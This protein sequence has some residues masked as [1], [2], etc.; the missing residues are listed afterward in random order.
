MDNPFEIPYCILEDAPENRHT[1]LLRP[2]IE[3]L[4]QVDVEHPVHSN[5]YNRFSVLR[6]DVQ[7]DT[8]EYW[9]SDN[10]EDKEI[11]ADLHSNSD[12][13]SDS[14]SAKETDKS[15]IKSKR[16]IRRKKTKS[17]AKAKNRKAHVRLGHDAQIRNADSK[18]DY[19]FNSREVQ[20]IR[21]QMYLS[22]QQKT[23]SSMPPEIQTKD[24]KMAL[25]A[26]SGY[27]HP[28]PP[29]HFKPTHPNQEK[30][31]FMKYLSRVI[32]TLFYISLYKGNWKQ[33]YRL[34]SILVR[35]FDTDVHQIW[36]LGVHMLCQLNTAEFEKFFHVEWMKFNPKS[37]VPKLSSKLLHDMA[38]LQN[39][40]L[41]P[42][43]YKNRDDPVLIRVLQSTVAQRRPMYDIILK[44]L[45]LLMRTS[46]NQH[47][48][49]GG[50]PEQTYVPGGILI[51]E[52]KSQYGNT[53]EE[54]QS[55]PN[56]HGNEQESTSEHEGPSR[57]EH[58]ESTNTTAVRRKKG[59]GNRR[60]S[61]T[62]SDPIDNTDTDTDTNT[63]TEN[64]LDDSTIRISGSKEPIVIRNADFNPKTDGHIPHQQLF[65]KALK[66]H[67]TPLHKQGTRVR[68]PTF[69][70]S[71]LWILV[72]TGRLSIVQ[73]ALE[74]L[75]LVVPT[76]IDARVELANL[77]SRILDIAGE[78][79]E[80]S[81]S[82]EYAW[83]KISLVESK[84]SELDD[85]WEKWK[86]QFTCR[87]KKRRKG[88]RQF[89]GYS[90]V[91]ASLNNLKKWVI[92]C[93]K[94]N[95]GDQKNFR[96][97]SNKPDFERPEESDES[98]DHD[99]YVTADEE[100]K[101]SKTSEDGAN[102]NAETRANA[103]EG[104]E[105]EEEEE[106]RKEMERLLGYS[107]MVDNDDDENKDRFGEE[108]EESEFGFEGE[109][110]DEEVQRE[111]A[112]LMGYVEEP[113][114]REFNEDE[115][116]DSNFKTENEQFFNEYNKWNN[117]DSESD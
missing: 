21:Q 88:V 81:V 66:R 58:V 95:K 101:E 39:P 100:D 68:T 74:P 79:H 67:S 51:P 55:V 69:T 73:R 78:A 18:L 35:T 94:K 25:I 116:E 62:E 48:L 90:D 27:E 89:E 82:E 17:D 97:K 59:K 113:N 44:F 93:L 76:S 103:N 46:R 99:G 115:D 109:E 56:Q 77:A 53:E 13:N 2:Y 26:L 106:I 19:E 42:L 15:S 7:E 5:P 23:R 108:L 104:E 9:I 92:G 20:H 114:N 6:D 50:Y 3:K 47:P 22:L 4:I 84:L 86:E 37:T 63:D 33:C 117:D 85:C 40:A 34:F 98:V 72:R 16:K 102:A 87:R 60:E 14:D 52:R 29:V 49:V 80:I 11:G 107:A 30:V 38:F 45:R 71:Y 8:L 65:R 54:T 41:V 110:D 36:T 96:K 112:R 10:E 43:L 61:T 83:E 111:M 105:E 75:L 70:L 24:I 57:Q 31:S 64:N 1:R 12:S 91:E 28:P 32:D